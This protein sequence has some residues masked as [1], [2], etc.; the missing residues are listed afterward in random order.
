M[1]AVKISWI[2]CHCEAL[3]ITFRRWRF[4]HSTTTQAT[5]SRI[6]WEFPNFRFVAK[7]AKF[8]ITVPNSIDVAKWPQHWRWILFYWLVTKT[9]TWIRTLILVIMLCYHTW[10]NMSCWHD[11]AHSS[12]LYS[13]LHHIFASYYKKVTK[14][15]LACYL[16][17]LHRIFL[18]FKL[19]K[20]VHSSVVTH[21]Q[22]DM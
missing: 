6:H 7:F 13:R 16:R 10:C 1:F 2:L 15:C 19:F 22:V 4:C 20:I 12:L 11:M 17:V 21:L 9:D 18:S 8:D 14:Q 5:Q 3:F